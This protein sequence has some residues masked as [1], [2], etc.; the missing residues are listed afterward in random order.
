M[1]RCL[2]PLLALSL[3]ACSGSPAPPPG[4]AQ[5][6][7]PIPGGWVPMPIPDDN[8]FTREGIELG[9]RL[10][11]DPILSGNNTQAC[12]SCH[13]QAKAF[14]DGRARSLGSH[15]NLVRRNAMML[16]NLAWQPLL[17]WDGRAATLEELA[18]IPIQDASEMDQALPELE[19]ELQEHAVYPALFEAAFPGEP[20]SAS[21]LAKALAQ[22]MRTLISAGS[23][24]DRLDTEE[25][26]ITPE[27]QRGMALLLAL[28]ANGPDSRPDLC[29][30]CHR[31]TF[32]LL[33]DDVRMGLFTSDR[34]RNNGLGPDPRDPGRVEI[35]GNEADRGAFK[36]PATRNLSYTAP[37]MHDGRFETLEEVVRHYNDKVVAGPGTDP[38]LLLDGAALKLR[39]EEADIVAI[40]AALRM[41]DDPAFTTNPAFADPFQD[42][43]TEPVKE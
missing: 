39:L 3:A 13:L 22:F 24:M 27:E 32:G 42:Q 9:R 16:A 7:I 33:P 29:D 12:A 36:V 4:P 15:G 21:N 18:L 20:V 10:F 5:V 8:S 34:V 40:T 26:H 14:T 37:Y 43:P 2:P 35:S 19:R 25:V 30:T 28:P 41:F 6:E 11:Y 38:R 17:F 31:F 1:R 23:R